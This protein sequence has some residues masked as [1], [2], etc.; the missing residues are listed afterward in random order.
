MLLR[1]LLA[2]TV[3]ELLYAAMAVRSETPP[4]ETVGAAWLEPRQ[5]EETLEH[6]FLWGALSLVYLLSLA[7]V[8]SKRAA[9][10]TLVALVLSSS[11]AFRAT[12]VVLPTSFHR[13]EPAVFLDA[14]DPLSKLVLEGAAHAPANRLDVDLARVL[15]SVFD[16]ASLALAPG[17]LRA[18]GLPAGL[19]LLHGWNPLV[20]KELAGSNRT[21]AFAFF[22]L[23]AAIR[24]RVRGR[25]FRAAALYG[26][27][28]AGPL[29]LWSTLVP[30]VR[31]LRAKAL[32]AL[33]VGLIAQGLHAASSSPSWA[34][35][36]G[37][38]P[39]GFTGASLLPTLHA[40]SRL[41]VTRHEVFPLAVAAT[42]WLAFVLR[43][44]ASSF[45][46]RRLPKEVLL[47]SGSFL[48]LAP[49]VLPWA[50][51]LFGYLGAF[52][53]NRGW[54]LFTLTAP[55]GYTALSGGE[56][57]F[58]LGFAQYFAPYAALVFFWLGR[59]DRDELG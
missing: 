8:S 21:E 55:L 48:F 23:L 1:L 13:D 18:A 9:S 15:P 12:L 7:A 33:G 41:F 34:E 56:S 57:T 22:L 25:G 51:T 47:A 10:R 49:Q 28:L 17:L 6:H 52:A 31:M 11:V 39:S 20:V 24:L 4:A 35:A 42:L 45:D 26:G 58:W 50:F 2:A 5:F 36:L 38:P 30:M 40:L 14:A 29:W 54:V 19:V 32:V 46:E 43:R 37:W 44:A 27:A 59:R 3:T 16:V 53:R